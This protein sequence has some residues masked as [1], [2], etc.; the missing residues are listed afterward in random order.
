MDSSDLKS[1]MLLARL[2][3][4]TLQILMQLFQLEC[5]VWQVTDIS[6]CAAR[7]EWSLNSQDKN[8]QGDSTNFPTKISPDKM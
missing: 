4:L 2:D 6:S 5:F 8:C 3:I 1:D 7:R